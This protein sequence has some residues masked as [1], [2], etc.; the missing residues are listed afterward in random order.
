MKLSPLNDLHLALGAKMTEF[1]GFLMPL[2][3]RSGVIE[4]HLACRNRAVVFDVSHLGLVE[5]NSPEAKELINQTL[6][7]DLDRIGPFRAQYS[8]L[9]NDRGGIEDDVII[10]WLKDKFYVMPNAVNTEGV[11]EKLGGVDI[12]KNRVFLALQGPESIR[13]LSQVFPGIGSLQS[14]HIQQFE[15]NKSEVLIG[16]TGYT[17]ERGVEI[18]SDIETGRALFN[19]FVRE[20]EIPPAGL[21]ARDTL[22]LEAG[23]VLHGQD[24]SPEITPLEA[25]LEWVV[26]FN[27]ASFVGKEALL[28]QKKEGIKRKLVGLVSAT[29]RPLRAH[30]DVYLGD[31]KV[32]QTTSGNYSPVLKKGI[33]LAFLGV[34]YLN[35]DTFMVNSEEVI[36]IKPPFVKLSK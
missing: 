29:R 7:N 8:H 32:G 31:A 10:W 26:S 3:Y 9:L 12:S 28:A 36:M 2:N 33:A 20:L 11:R 34:S 13:L 15:F 30:L 6:T 27:K 35:H 17:G 14:F 25:N 1:G 16:A 18:F 4:E 23:L 19:L 21:G 5:L 24:I 22:R